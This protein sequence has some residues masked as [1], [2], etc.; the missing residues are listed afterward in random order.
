MEFL[1]QIILKESIGEEEERIT[2]FNKWLWFDNIWEYL[3]K[4]NY[5]VVQIKK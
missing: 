2:F 1:I 5:Y 3:D 4:F